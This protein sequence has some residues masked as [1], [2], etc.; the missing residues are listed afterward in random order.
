MQLV[1]E[2]DHLVLV[3]HDSCIKQ[4]KLWHLLILLKFVQPLLV[5]HAWGNDPTTAFSEA[6]VTV[7]MVV[8]RGTLI[9]LAG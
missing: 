6:K 2:I 9:L 8:Q 5:L 4:L 3:Q 7:S 1:H